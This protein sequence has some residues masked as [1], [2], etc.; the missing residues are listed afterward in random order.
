M[1]ELQK[2]TKIASSGLRAQGVRLRT[3]SENLANADS[4]P[5]S[6]DVLPYRR[7]VV[8]FKNALD[9]EV[10]LELVKVHRISGDRSEF[11]KRFDPNH[12]A[13]D[14]DGYVLAPN[15]NSLIELMDMREAQRS[16]EANLN[17]ISTSKA[18]VQ[19]TVEML[20]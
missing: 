15:V 12:P 17:V 2:S 19:R 10:N 8:S 11:N 5:T 13:A 6:P 20:R 4:L 16:Y 14:R 7:K 9:K 18:M 1:D 3:I